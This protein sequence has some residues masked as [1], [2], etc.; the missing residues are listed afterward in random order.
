MVIMGQSFLTSLIQAREKNKKLQE[1]QPVRTVRPAKSKQSAHFFKSFAVCL[2]V[3][4]LRKKV[5]ANK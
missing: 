4:W 1:G 2:I 5:R 3:F